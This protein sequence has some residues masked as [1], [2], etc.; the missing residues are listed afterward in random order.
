MRKT[1]SGM[2]VMLAVLAM[3]LAAAGLATAEERIQLAI[4][5][6]TSNSMDGLIEQAKSQLWKV[7]N[8]MARSRKSGKSPA[9][10]VALFE[11]GNDGLPESEGH[12]RM[13]CGLTTDLDRISEELFK[14]TTNG[15]SEY[16]GMVIDRAT[17]RLGWSAAR[18]ALKVVYIAGNEPFDQGPVSFANACRRAITKGIVVNTIF[19]GLREEG[20]ASF[21]KKGADLADGRYMSI[22]QDQV[23]AEIATP[24]DEEIVRLG[25]EVNKT[26]I[27]F[28]SAGEASKS[29]QEAQDSNAAS[30][31]SGSSV[32]RSVAKAQAQYVN[33]GWDLIDALR[34]GSLK[35][36]DLKEEELPAEM[37]KMAP[38]Q[39]ETYVKEA[40]GRRAELQ[41]KIN[42]LNDQRRA[43]VA[44]AAT[45]TAEQNTLDAA[46]ISSVR[47][48]AKQKGYTIE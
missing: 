8:E 1:G 40:E 2:K 31:G 47:D 37:R 43:F 12:I 20:I 5:L 38:A 36:K 26:Y 39:R 23:V 45:Q 34:G 32:Q 10:E 6:D 22:D 42:R 14:L 29:R 33:S 9:L 7:V 35:L 46:I 17:A 11:Y 28:G 48:L 30:M 44:K 16:C 18:D 13:V 15:G 27:A 25:E 4:L 3:G 24:F 19:C 41:S 21:W